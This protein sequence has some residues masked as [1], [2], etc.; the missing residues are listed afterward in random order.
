MA[1]SAWVSDFD[2][3]EIVYINDDITTID[4]FNSTKK[5]VSDSL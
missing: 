4:Y 1:L 5:Y 3:C 2:H